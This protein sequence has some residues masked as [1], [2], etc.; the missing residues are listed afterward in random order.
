MKKYLKFIVFGVLVLGLYFYLSIDSNN[1]DFELAPSIPSASNLAGSLTSSGFY[2]LTEEQLALTAS[3][4]CPEGY[5]LKGSVLKSGVDMAFVFKPVRSDVDQNLN[6]LREVSGSHQFSFLKFDYKKYTEVEKALIAEV[7]AGDMTQAQAQADLAGKGFY[8][9]FSK[10]YDLQDVSSSTKFLRSFEPLIVVASKPFKYC[11]MSDSALLGLEK[12]FNPESLEPKFW[13]IVYLPETSFDKDIFDKIYSSNIFNA[14]D[15]LSFTDG[16]K[17]PKGVYRIKFN[18]SLR[19]SS[20]NSDVRGSADVLESR[21]QAFLPKDQALTLANDVSEITDVKSLDNLLCD[22]EAAFDSEDDRGPVDMINNQICVN[23][24]KLDRMDLSKFEVTQDGSNLRIFRSGNYYE[25]PR[26]LKIFYKDT[27]GLDK[28][29]YFHKSYVDFRDTEEGID[30]GLKGQ[31]ILR[32]CDENNRCEI[33]KDY[34]AYRYSFVDIESFND[35]TSTDSVTWGDISKNYYL[36]ESSDDDMDGSVDDYKYS[37]SSPEFFN[38]NGETNVNESK[39][40]ETV[41]YNTNILDQIAYVADVRDV[42]LVDNEKLFE[43]RLSILPLLRNN[44]FF[45]SVGTV[46]SGKQGPVKFECKDLIPSSIT[47]GDALTNSLESLNLEDKRDLFLNPTNKQ[48]LI[49]SCQSY[50]RAVII[51][52]VSVF[53]DNNGDF[54]PKMVALSALFKDIYP[55]S[56]KKDLT[57]VY[58][59]VFNE[60]SVNE[61]SPVYNAFVNVDFADNPEVSEVTTIEN[62]DRFIL[63]EPANLSVAA[64]NSVS[65]KGVDSSVV[66]YLKGE[67]GKNEFISKCKNL[68]RDFARRFL[69][70]ESDGTFNLN[71]VSLTAFTHDVYGSEAEGMLRFIYGEALSGADIPEE[72]KTIYFKNK[73]LISRSNVRSED[74]Q[75]L[76]YIL[77]SSS[78]GFLDIVT[79]I[80]AKYYF[81]DRQSISFF[82]N[83]DGTDT[84]EQQKFFDFINRALARGDITDDGQSSFIQKFNDRVD[85]LEN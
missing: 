14:N 36:I 26:L 85:S 27:S 35:K 2:K 71:L 30:R 28:V 45:G 73:F 44:V 6:L 19:I 38:P 50:A 7:K 82:K 61:G 60:V 16:V 10:Y 8:R 65:V 78:D 66:Q 39:L 1:E 5:E 29:I 12:D 15:E 79:E 64:S 69:W 37:I 3:Q 77:P 51:T 41:L 75:L 11:G 22:G 67:A 53:Q 43:E 55:D 21:I 74:P 72:V 46:E 76:F 63:S 54:N 42:L 20:E 34:A 31:L 18:D 70:N 52:R 58:E 24:D 62:C 4:T 17:I 23:F 84:G 33:E 56:F 80:E 48:K 32:F 83:G 49:N 59:Q 13:N 25:L 47:F 40:S 81:I 9:N 57:Q 68:V